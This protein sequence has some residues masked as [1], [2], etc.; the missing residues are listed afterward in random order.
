MTPFCCS[1]TGAVQEISTDLDSK[2]SLVNIVGGAPGAS[3]GVVREMLLLNGPC[4]T[5]V[6]AAI[7]QL[8]ATNGFRDPMM[9][10]VALVPIRKLELPIVEVMLME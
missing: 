3:S 7:I 5:D 6:C 2:L 4:P 9:Y 1:T 8:Y 10:C